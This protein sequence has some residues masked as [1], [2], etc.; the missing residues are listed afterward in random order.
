M[1][2]SIITATFNSEKT[3]QDTIN[4]ILAQSY[5]DYEYIIIDGASTDGTLNLITNNMDAFQGRL[6]VISEP[7]KSLYEAMNKGL[8]MA[9]GDVV[10]ILN[11][12]DYFSSNNI[13]QVVADNMQDESIDAI[14]GD[15]HYVDRANPQKTV[16]RY[17]SRIFK[18]WLMRMGFMPAHPSFYC[19]KSVFTRIGLYNTSYQLAAD[20]ELLLRIL[21]I[22][23]IPTRYIPIDFVTMRRGGISNAGIQS[24][25]TIFKEH[26]K[27]LAN[28]NVYSNCIFLGTRYIYKILELLSSTAKVGRHDD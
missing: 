9:T 23:K 4:S 24:Y 14:Y 8:K 19:R 13:L 21:L 28:N 18:P 17:S 22:N 15:V 16:R 26:K 5:V 11:A 10:G 1:K 6:K 3:L 20:F 25:L 2:I 7:D 27:A 12:D